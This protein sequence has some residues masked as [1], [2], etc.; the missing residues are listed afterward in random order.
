MS[1]THG[2]RKTTWLL[3]KV[4]QTSRRYKRE[5]VGQGITTKERQPSNTP[6]LEIP[7]DDAANKRENIHYT[8]SEQMYGWGINGTPNPFVLSIGVAISFFNLEISAAA[9]YGIHFIQREHSE[10]KL[11]KL[12]SANVIFKKSTVPLKVCGDKG[13][14]RFTWTTSRM[15]H[16][17]HVNG[18]LE[19]TTF[20]ILVHI[21][22]GH[23][24][25]T[26]NRRFR[27]LLSAWVA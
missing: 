27:A 12:Q 25:E 23:T 15:T 26:G 4:K 11:K 20:Q 6:V 9:T 22:R 18:L 7:G 1:W 24:K 2:W 3:T 5:E 21:G 13:S 17:R 19:R 16:G 10:N 14:K 8:H